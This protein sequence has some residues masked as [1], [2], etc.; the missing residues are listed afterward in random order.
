[1]LFLLNNAFKNKEMLVLALISLPLRFSMRLKV[2]QRF[3]CVET[4]RVLVHLTSFL[5][6]N[7]F[8]HK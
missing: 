3:Y 8:Q 4:D 1:M 6:K 2:S 7:T 5:L